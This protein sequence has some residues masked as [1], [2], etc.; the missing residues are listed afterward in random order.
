MK[1][2]GKV[3]KIYEG[4]FGDTLP[5]EIIEE[6][7][8]ICDGCPYNS[9]NVNTSKLVE[10]RNTLT[11]AY[12]TLC[13]CQIKEKTQSPHE[14]CAAYMAGE[15]KKWFRVKMETMEKENLNLIQTGS[16]LFD[17]TTEGD[18]FVLNLGKIRVNEDTEGEIYLEG[19][20]PLKLNNVTV[21]CGCVST[22]SSVNGEG[23][24][25]NFRINVNS[26]GYGSG[27]KT[28]T[29]YY[30]ENGENREQVIRLKY[31]RVA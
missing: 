20:T 8:K 4:F 19:S 22:S 2:I 11:G 7:R 31:F 26:V 3:R 23:I 18:K 10:L 14:E 16:K 21:S 5:E 17:L 15:E 13:K 28:I 25:I 9:K 30:E 27:A 1:E 29:V 12:C 6:R 24:T